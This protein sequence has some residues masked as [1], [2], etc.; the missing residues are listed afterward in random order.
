MA[1]QVEDGTGLTDSNAYI[2]EVFFDDFHTDR[3]RDL[4]PFTTTQKE[5]AI[6]RASDYIEK[7]FGRKFRGVRRSKN[8][9]MEWPR[10][11]AFDND[12]FML[13]E[14]DLIPRQLEK[15]TAE[16]AYQALLD[17][18]LAPPAPSPVPPQDLSDVSTP[19]STEPVITG[20]VKS[21][22]ERVEGAVTDSKEYSTSSEVARLRDVQNTSSL[23]S[24]AYLRP[25]PAADMWL[26]ELLAPPSMRRLV[27]G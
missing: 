13:N 1:F 7:R 21:S 16:Y 5:N 15:A 10:L 19:P 6:V 22:T 14:V 25:I 3:G 11:D 24:G 9:A 26:E 27:R 18:E 2:A 23:V 12:D 8:Q 4:V 20:F 17:G